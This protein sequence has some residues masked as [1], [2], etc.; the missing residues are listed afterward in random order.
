MH[1]RSEQINL[2]SNTDRSEKKRQQYSNSGTSIPYFGQW[3]D[4]LDRKSTKTLDLKHTLDQKDHKHLWNI[5]CSSQRGIFLS[6]AQETFSRMDDMLGCKTN[7]RKLKG[8]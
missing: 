2:L 3:I 6:R 5:P 7:T 8:I 4:N 1:V